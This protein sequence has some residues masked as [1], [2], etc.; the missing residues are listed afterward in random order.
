MHWVRRLIHQ[1]SI[2]THARSLGDTNVDFVRR[3]LQKAARFVDKAE[4]SAK[5]AARVPAEPEVVEA[6]NDADDEGDAQQHSQKRRKVSAWNIFFGDS[7]RGPNRGSTAPGKAFSEQYEAVM[8]AGGE[9][10]ARLLARVEEANRR[11]DLGEQKPLG[12]HS[13]DLNRQRQ[14]QLT[15]LAYHNPAALSIA[16]QPVALQDADGNC[17]ALVQVNHAGELSTLKRVLREESRREAAAERNAADSIVAFHADASGGMEILDNISADVP[18]LSTMKDDVLAQCSCTDASTDVKHTFLEWH[19]SDLAKM[20]ASISSTKGTTMLGKE[21]HKQLGLMYSQLCGTVPGTQPAD[22]DDSKLDET[23]CCKAGMCI[24]T[25]RGLT[26]EQFRKALVAHVKSACPPGSRNRNALA[27][28]RVVVLCIGQPP[29]AEGEVLSAASSGS[30]PQAGEPA[31][32]SPL[33]LTWW[34]IANQSSP[35][36][37]RDTC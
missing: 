27:A 6:A 37:G 14:Q 33:Q 26:T 36:G 21:L 20:A 28:S 12:P 25:G 4:K 1:Y 11:I 29:P 16:A 7:A 5:A 35:L 19:P 22:F 13:R 30:E 24:C 9:E 32:S 23:P 34:H 10:K 8:S 17:S 31:V 3:G 18:M 2:Q 15:M